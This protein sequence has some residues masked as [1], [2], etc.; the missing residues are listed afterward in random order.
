MNNRK[1]AAFTLIELLIA[2]TVLSFISLSIYT[3]TSNSFSLRE[4]L[5]R[6]ND[7]YNSVR[8]AVDVV[9][10][11][12]A[13]MYVPQAASMPGDAG[14]NIYD[15]PL[16]VDARNTTPPPPGFPY[17]EIMKFWSV[18][19]N[20]SG[21]RYTRFNGN[22]TE[23]TFVANSHIRL[24]RDTPECEFVKISYSLSDGLK[25][26]ANKR[27]IKVEDTDVFTDA[28]SSDTAISYTLLSN[29]KS[30]KL[31][32]LD[33]RSDAWHSKWDS[34]A[35]DFKHVYPQV[36]E[37]SLVVAGPDTRNPNA[38]FKVTQAFRPEMAL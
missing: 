26:G 30:L 6:D 10:R 32:Y 11:D 17:G 18:P 28:S 5:E 9:G 8:A 38:E 2:I 20:P 24:Y 13:H 31:R 34:V 36:I 19:I 35:V 23:V 16:N 25:S 14:K 33:G 22:E 3:G 27:L 12:L 37:V 29:V 15:D 1:R 21:F 7:F 4:N